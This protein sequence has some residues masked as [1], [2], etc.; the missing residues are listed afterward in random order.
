VR[1]SFYPF[2][3]G[4]LH[5][6]P[7]ILPKPPW[8]ITNREADEVMRKLTYFHGKPSPL[9]LPSIFLSALRG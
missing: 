4:A 9:K 5:G 7:A 8:F 2:P 6:K 3:R 1:G